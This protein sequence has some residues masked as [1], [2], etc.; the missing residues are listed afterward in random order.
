L[1][2]NSIASLNLKKYK[3]LEYV[4]VDKNVEVTLPTSLSEDVV[5]RW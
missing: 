1:T 2:D 5:R 3:K 4:Y